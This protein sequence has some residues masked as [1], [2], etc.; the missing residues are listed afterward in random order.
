MKEIEKMKA[1]L[2]YSYDDKEISLLK[3]KAIKNSTKFN[4]ID[5]SDFEKQYDV[6]CEILGSVGNNVMMCKRFSFDNA[7]LLI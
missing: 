7:T 4:S 5:D 2:E 1:G 3:L 6:L